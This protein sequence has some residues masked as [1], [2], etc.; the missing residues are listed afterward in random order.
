MIYRALT[1]TIPLGSERSIPGLHG[2]KNIISEMEFLFP[3]PEDI[4]P[5]LSDPRPGKLVIERGYI[6][7]FVDLVV[8]HEGRVYFADWKSD[9]LP[10]Y[11]PEQIAMHVEAHYDTQVKLYSLALVKALMIDSEAAYQESFGGLF[12]VFLRALS[13]NDDDPRG[14]YFEQPVGPISCSTRTSSNDSSSGPERGV[15]EKATRPITARHG[16]RGDFG[17]TPASLP[18]N[19]AAL[20]RTSYAGIARS[21]S[22]SRHSTASKMRL[23]S[24]PGNWH[25][26]RRGSSRSSSKP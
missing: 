7:G 26:G 22:R 9:V 15:H 4:H 20:S 14:V 17:A 5:S 8:E 16:A 11:E 3:F 1:M 19:A 24:L 23:R 21:A 12:Y 13:R 18:D 6:K 2:C 25:A 10:S